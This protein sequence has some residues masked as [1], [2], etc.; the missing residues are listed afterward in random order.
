MSSTLPASQK[1]RIHT[2]V[3]SASVCAWQRREKLK[4]MLHRSG[5][6]GN[7]RR[8]K[9]S[10]VYGAGV[11][12]VMGLRGIRTWGMAEE[13]YKLHAFTSLLFF[14]RHYKILSGNLKK[15]T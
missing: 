5:G 7:G 2:T 1:K 15:H 8:R 9:R 6:L 11:P 12:K 4:A 13:R 14:L 3:M 10:I